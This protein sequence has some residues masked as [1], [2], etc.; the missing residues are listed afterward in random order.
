[1]GLIGFALWLV[2]GLAGAWL[3]VTG[4]K[5][6]FGL[7]RDYRE[8]W[9]VQVFGLALVLMAAFVTYQSYRASRGLPVPG[10]IF[11]VYGIGGFT[12]LLVV[13][14]VWGGRRMPRNTE[15]GGAATVTNEPQGILRK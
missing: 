9:P 2:L 6:V 11:Y 12:V 14:A 1:M 7:P 10:G 8:G 3:L 13:L 15:A 4:R 5:M